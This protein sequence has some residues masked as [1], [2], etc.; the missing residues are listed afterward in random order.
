LI[1]GE[2]NASRKR[3]VVP[4]GRQR[5]AVTEFTS[6]KDDEPATSGKAI[7]LDSCLRW[8][9]LKDFG[10]PVPEGVVWETGIEYANPDDEHL[11][12][13]LAQPV[14]QTFRSISA[15]K[16]FIVRMAR[17]SAGAREAHGPPHPRRAGPAS[18][19]PRAM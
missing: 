8:D 12:W 16:R 5:V 2:L 17:P 19:A 11:P 10:I 4:P 7:L 14:A 13:N 1:D 15:A 18:P 6:G 3:I 9:V